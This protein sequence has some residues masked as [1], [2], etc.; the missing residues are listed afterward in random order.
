MGGIRGRDYPIVNGCVF[1]ISLLV[2]TVNLLV[3]IAYA[4]ID[5]RI[6]NQF[7]SVRK[8]AKMINEFTQLE[9]TP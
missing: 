8:R 1:I 6:K 4:F 2:C 7:I 5:P 9:E 3:D